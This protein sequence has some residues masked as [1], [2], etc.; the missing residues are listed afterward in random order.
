VLKKNVEMYPAREPDDRK[1]QRERLIYFADYLNSRNSQVENTADI[2]WWY[3][4]RG[5][6]KWF[7]G[8]TIGLISGCLL[9][10]SGGLAASQ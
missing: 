4:P 8:G 1:I 5:V 7:V 6:P 9:G 3:L 10:A 2:E